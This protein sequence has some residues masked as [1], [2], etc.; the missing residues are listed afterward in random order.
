MA[1]NTK[2]DSR[3]DITDLSYFPRSNPHMVARATPM[4]YQIMFFPGNDR[5]HDFFRHAAG[6]DANDNGLFSYQQGDM[7]A[8]FPTNFPSILQSIVGTDQVIET[9]EV[10]VGDRCYHHSYTPFVDNREDIF[11]NITDITDRKRVEGALKE[12]EG[13][14]YSIFEHSN[15]AIFLLDPQQNQ[16]LDANAKACQMLGYK[17]EELLLRPISDIH[18]D[19]MPQMM[20]FA[21][22]VS[23]QGDGWTDALTCMTKVGRV[24][25][26]EISASATVIDGCPSIIAVVR[27]VTERQR[28][29]RVLD[30]EI[31]SKYN[32]ETILGNSPFLKKALKDVDL[33]A[34]TDA[35]V[36]IL[37]ETG[38]G[39]ELICR[40]IHHTS[41][42]CSSPLVKINCA[43]IP[44]GLI[45]SE[46]FG[47][48]KGAF[49]GA[50]GQKRGRFE[51]AHEGTIFLD[52]VGDLPLET[53]PKLLR[54][55]Q[56]QEFERVGG[57]R[58]LQVNVRIIAATHR[59]L[60]GMVKRGEFRE[61]L[62]YRLNVFPIHVPSLRERKEDIPL[63]SEFFGRRICERYGRPPCTFSDEA[64]DRLQSYSWPGN[65]RELENIIERAAILSKGQVIEV[66]HIQVTDDPHPEVAGG[67][68]SLNDMEREHIIAALRAC[69]GKVSG[70]GGAAELLDMKPSTLDSRLRKLR[71][72]PGEFRG[73]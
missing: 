67:I 55:L 11:I 71:I 69:H 16:I 73:S 41:E 59:N 49:T 47:H 14:F 63:L 6:Q 61:D 35:S 65:V 19:E 3:A 50:I 27:D 17:R 48:E 37:G 36:L 18:P 13:R 57:T 1:G 26:A 58:T 39:K 38:T 53:Q 51:L 25:S 44:S 21:K 46:L 8:L 45:E 12:S 40:A 24:L 42:R 62:F 29:A 15:D 2:Q 32:Y 66:Q 64:V 31:R 52:E 10:W 30:D 5:T 43:A 54:L 56:E 22:T 33:V 68:R 34:P 7:A 60:E 4:A 72:N 23:E 20:R 28:V 70:A 9:Q